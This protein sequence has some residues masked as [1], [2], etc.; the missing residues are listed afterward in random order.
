M[1]IM[2]GHEMCVIQRMRWSICPL[3]L[4]N[5][6]SGGLYPPAFVRNAKRLHDAG[7]HLCVISRGDKTDDDAMAT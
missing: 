3:L 2:A 7:V 1:P 5:W 4:C 6:M